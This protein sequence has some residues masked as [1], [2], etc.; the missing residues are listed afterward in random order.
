MLDQPIYGPGL[1]ECGCGERT[2]LAPRTTTSRG[3]VKGQPQRF[4]FGHNRRK[5]VRYEIRDCGH[6]TPCWVW[7]LST[8]NSGYG[9]MGV[10][11]AN[12]A[13]HRVYYERHIG[14]VPEGFDLDHLCR[15]RAC[16]NPAHLEPVTR[17]ENVRRGLS[18]KLSDADR[19]RICELRAE[20]VKSMALA[21]QYGVTQTYI[22]RIVKA[23][24]G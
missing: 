4:V 17:Q 14:P 11:G 1:C 19:A 7:L 5:A 20:G 2:R 10:D 3:N 15:N 16:V 9:V 18:A 23:G 8:W 22:C 21:K 6:E 13:A 12:S 24:R